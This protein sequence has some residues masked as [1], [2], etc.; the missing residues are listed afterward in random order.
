MESDMQKPKFSWMVMICLITVFIL[1]AQTHMAEKTLILSVIATLAG[2]LLLVDF[3]QFRL[4]VS[5]TFLTGVLNSEHNKS[6]Q[7]LPGMMR[8]TLHPQFWLLFSQKSLYEHFDL[9]TV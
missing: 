8:L 9:K 6:Y 1:I 2:S 7:Q 4:Y 3:L 5:Y